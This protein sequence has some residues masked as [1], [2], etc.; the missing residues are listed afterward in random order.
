MS[1]NKVRDITIIALFSAILFVQEQIISLIPNVQL[2][3]FFIVVYSKVFGLKRTLIIILIH[4][5]L[6]NLINASFSLIYLPF[7]LIGWSIIPIVI[8][9]IFK[10]TENPIVL[11]IVGVGCSFIY[12]WMFMIPNWLLTDVDIWAYFINDIIF[13]V[14][15][16]I[17]SFLTI[18]WLYKP[19]TKLLIKLINK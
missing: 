8:C 15:L 5:I 4:T 12:C 10:D 19:C 9:T 1:N 17:S 18:L 11:A 16:A 2:T 6:D 13:E 14:I 7:M 3:V